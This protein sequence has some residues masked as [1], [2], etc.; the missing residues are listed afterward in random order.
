M[1][2]KA[3]FKKYWLNVLQ[4]IGVLTATFTLR[5]EFI[6]LSGIVWWIGLC[7]FLALYL[8]SIYEIPIK[9]GIK[10]GFTKDKIMKEVLFVWALPLIIGYLLAE[11]LIR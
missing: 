8:A 5:Y 3:S 11:H 10:N 4:F 7:F 2:M 1:I 9:I 6:N